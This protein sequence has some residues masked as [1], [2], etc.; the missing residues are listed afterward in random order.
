LAAAVA[1]SILLVGLP[2]VLDSFRIMQ[3]TL[4]IILALFTLSLAFIWGY[5]G[6]LCFG[7]A[8]FFGIGGYTF[9]IAA[10]NIGETTI[11]LALG[12]AVPALCAAALGYFIFYGRLT[13]VYLGIVTMVFALILWKLLNSTSS[14]EYAIGVARLGGFNGITAVPPLNIPG[15]PGRQLD[16]TEGFQFAAGLLVVTYAALKLLL[17]SRFGRVAVGIRENETRASL[18]GYDVRLRKLLVFTIGGAIA[19]MAGALYAS[20]QSF[21]DP[22]ALSLEMSAKVVIWVMAGGAGTLL[23]PIAGCMALQYLS[24]A[25]ADVQW[26]NSQLLFGAILCVM[27][28]L[29][30]RGILPSLG[31]ASFAVYRRLRGP[32]EHSKEPLNKPWTRQ[33]AAK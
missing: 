14:P 15:N 11:P 12:I 30:P 10:L 28:R 3:M 6:I 17:H 16:P 7:Q 29:L 1:G 20:Y 8:A 21:I 32:V 27:V 19:G 2:Q 13:E 25:L 9:G 26:S 5:G 24:F 33:E 18:L 31:D 22:N 23:G 4:Y